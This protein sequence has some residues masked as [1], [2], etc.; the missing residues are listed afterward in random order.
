M[1]TLF[2]INFL[3]LKDL[4]KMPKYLRRKCE[5]KRGDKNKFGERK[6]IEKDGDNQGDFYS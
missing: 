1:Q 6:L 5:K 4:T 3:D 2:K